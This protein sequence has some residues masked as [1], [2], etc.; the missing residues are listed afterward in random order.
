MFL[1]FVVV[2]LGFAFVILCGFLILLVLIQPAKGGGMGGLSGGAGGAIS[3][4]LGAT[5]GEKSLARWTSI[6][7][8]IFFGLCLALT[9]IGNTASS[10]RLDLGASDTQAGTPAQ[11]APAGAGAQGTGGPDAQ[12]P[13]PGSQPPASEE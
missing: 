9:L 5:Q 1:T 13:A 6:G 7:M 12:A 10:N 11:Q 3:E 8:A 4:T 2:V